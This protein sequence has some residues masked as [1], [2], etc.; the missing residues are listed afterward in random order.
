MTSSSGSFFS[1]GYP[2]N[3]YDNTNCRY[4]IR[5]PQG[6]RIVLTVHG[7][8]MESCCDF[9]HISEAG[10]QVA[11]LTGYHPTTNVHFVSNQTQLDVGFITDGSVVRGGF[12]AS[13]YSFP[14]GKLA[15]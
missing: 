3:Y 7:Y 9:L 14:A 2:G 6:R 1:P 10:Q 11:Q 4:H 5:V 8:S 15:V 12:N 13:Y